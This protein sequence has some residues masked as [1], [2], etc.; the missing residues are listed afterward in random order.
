[1]QIKRKNQISLIISAIYLSSILCSCGSFKK[2]SQ[3]SSPMNDSESYLTNTTTTGALI[4]HDYREINHLRI[5][6]SQIFLVEEDNY[7]VYLFSPTC[8]HCNQIKNRMIEYALNPT[9]PLYFVQESTSVEIND[10][11]AND[12]NVDN[13]DDLGI[14]GYP[15]LLNLVNHAVIKH[16]SGVTQILNEINS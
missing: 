1:M 4:N 13:L 12:L 15:T 14:R 6:W 3:T 2:T 7:Y 16:L 10:S 5:F 11:K 9:I 8:S